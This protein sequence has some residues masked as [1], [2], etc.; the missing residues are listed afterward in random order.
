M[1][2]TEVQEIISGL[3][4]RYFLTFLQCQLDHTLSPYIQTYFPILVGHHNDALY[5]QHYDVVSCTILKRNLFDN[6]CYGVYFRNIHWIECNLKKRGL[7][8]N[9]IGYGDQILW[10]SKC[11]S[12]DLIT[13]QPMVP[14]YVNFIILLIIN[15]IYI[16]ER[17]YNSSN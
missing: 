5:C 6:R 3:L 4:G 9:L 14:I 13:K 16:W 2:Y 7:D 15:Y 17:Y 12:K 11:I 10:S 1:V 8:M